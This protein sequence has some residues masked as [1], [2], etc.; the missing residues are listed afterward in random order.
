MPSLFVTDLD[1]LS[2]RE[3]SWLHKVDIKFDWWLAIGLFVVLG[4]GFLTLYSALI[5]ETRMFIRHAV[6]VVLGVIAM[7][8]V[9]QLP[10]RTIIQYTP[11]FYIGCILVL[12]VVYFA[13][14]ESKGSKRWLDLPLLPRF[15]PSELLKIAIPLM[16]AT[17]LRD[18]RWP[19]SLLE[20]T[21]SAAIIVIP[22]GLVFVQ[23]DLGTTLLL[24]AGSSSII[25]L[26]GMSWR[27][28]LIASGAFLVS[29]PLIWNF[30]MHEYQ[31]QRVLTMFN[32]EADALGSG[33]NIIQSK[34]ALGS[35]GLFGKGWAE[36]TQIQLEFLPAGHTDFILAVLGEEMGLFGCAVLLVAFV[37]IFIRGL[38]M[39]LH[40]PDDFSKYAICGITTM[41]FIYVLVNILMACGLLPVVG[42]PLPLISYGGTSAI[43]FLLAFGVIVALYKK[44]EI[45]IK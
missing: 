32:P 25:V 9:A 38:Q 31:K 45:S 20:L 11:Y 27:H 19:L 8:C 16:L 40:V 4:L 6:L 34:T 35:G 7:F 3:S 18:R 12:V 21:V 17:Y 14:Y 42:V 29:L 2:A 26:A 5:D 44:R 13:G 23:P 30:G 41:F 43:T 36:G 28:I 24:A 22:L 33:W 39:G 15:Q 10:S 1:W 37:I